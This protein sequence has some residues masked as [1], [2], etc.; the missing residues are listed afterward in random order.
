MSHVFISYS[1]SDIEFAEQLDTALV[2][3]NYTVWRDKKDI[4]PTSKWAADISRAIIDAEAFLF[5]ISPAS[6]GS[7]SCA[8]EIAQAV[9]QRK[10]IVPVLRT[11]VSEELKTGKV[12]LALAEVNWIFFRDSDDFNTSVQQLDD[13]LHTDLAYWQQAAEM[14]QRARQWQAH[15]QDHSMLLRGGELASAE[16]LLVEGASRK[17]A[18]SP[19][20][21]QFVA[22]SRTARAKGQRRRL[23][24]FTAL[25]MVLAILIVLVGA[26]A[27]V[28][29]NAKAEAQ[30]NARVALSHQFAGESNTARLDNRLDL[31]LMLGVK[32]TQLDENPDTRSSLAAAVAD[33]PYLENLLQV[34]DSSPAKFASTLTYAADGN[35]IFAGTSD[36]QILWWD[37]ATKTRHRLAPPASQRATYISSLAVSPSGKS[38]VYINGDGL[39]LWTNFTSSGFTSSTSPV[40]LVSYTTYDYY[41][42][43]LA[44]AFTS[45]QTFTV[46]GANCPGTKCI[47]TADVQTWNVASQ[48]ARIADK[49][50]GTPGTS[51]FD[52]FAAIGPDGSTI[53]ISCNDA[54][55][56]HQIEQVDLATGNITARQTDSKRTVGQ[57]VFDHDGR[58]LAALECTTHGCDRVQ[59]WNVADHSDNASTLDPHTYLQD[60]DLNQDGSR[61]LAGGC[62]SASDC[63]DGKLHVWKVSTDDID[64]VTGPF[65]THLNDVDL[66]AFAPDG[67]H[68]VSKAK[69][70]DELMVWD[71]AAAES[72][73]NV[74]A[75]SL[76][77]QI[78]RTIFKRPPNDTD[79]Q[80]Y[81]AVL[82]LDARTLFE[83]TGDQL[84]VFNVADGTQI[85]S[86][87]LKPS[88]GDVF[89]LG[90]NADGTRLAALT[91]YD[92][93]L[94]KWDGHVLTELTPISETLGQ[95]YYY[96]GFAFDKDGTRLA[97]ANNYC[98]PAN[99]PCASGPSGQ[100]ELWN[101]DTS[102]LIK[103]RVD[104]NTDGGY[105]ANAYQV[106]FSPDGNHV[107]VAFY[108]AW[109]TNPGLTD[110]TAWYDH[111][112]SL[113]NVTSDTLT[114]HLYK[115]H[116]TATG[117]IDYS[118]DGQVLASIDIYGTAILWEGASGD[119]IKTFT[120]FR[121]QQPELGVNDYFSHDGRYLAVTGGGFEGDQNVIAVWNVASQ[122]M[123][124]LQPVNNEL[125]QGQSGAEVVNVQFSQDDQTMFWTV[126]RDN[127]GATY[128]ST[129][130]VA[131]WQRQ[132]CQ[133]VEDRA[134]TQTEWDQFGTSGQRPSDCMAQLAT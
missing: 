83:T 88:D 53:A 105:T 7:T 13:A 81:L 121:R 113:W 41:Y 82:S 106:A 61:L 24:F 38:L 114:P 16:R 57:L 50:Y 30:H 96:D 54:C 84:S 87:P 63:S 118:P 22:K 26:L 131:S 116:D 8:S 11:D 79:P 66:V 55:P 76:S 103:R 62:S 6:I 70:D 115:G 128:S 48:G 110:Y 15:S 21:V 5:I 12:P 134:F 17:P 49:P 132:A 75:D 80:L 104:P 78:R 67:K 19:L 20:Q 1:R 36:G 68:V 37:Y 35:E 42:D 125:M 40:K 71:V 14:Q 126:A 56:S 69:N 89:Q 10:R 119:P 120:A 31:A 95:Q 64:P 100:I 109:L 101:T 124:A 18:P 4:P 94:W 52:D 25:S 98:L 112:I 111:D 27:A 108:P 58:K 97:A 46:V 73:S 51:H 3:R 92:I 60:I 91:Q 23:S 9:E 90:F 129:L 102:T 85:Q 122:Q 72:A 34:S 107:A 74:T 47:T 65:G 2:A 59:V 33:E 99:A 39:W 43:T 32:A 133:M 123:L 93:Y 127:I 29:N 86:F 44:L 28:V 117:G 45:E 130:N 77:H